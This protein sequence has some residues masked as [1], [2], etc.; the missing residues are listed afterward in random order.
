MSKLEVNGYYT[1][2][3]NNLYFIDFENTCNSLDQYKTELVKNAKR[4]R[5]YEL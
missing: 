1:V 4:N 2:S 3:N 5:H